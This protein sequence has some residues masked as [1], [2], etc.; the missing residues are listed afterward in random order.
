MPYWEEGDPGEGRVGGEHCLHVL[1]AILRRRRDGSSGIQ[2]GTRGGPSLERETFPERVSLV[3]S[4]SVRWV[5]SLLDHW[6][7]ELSVLTAHTVYPGAA[8]SAL[9]G[10]VR[11]ADAQAPPPPAGTCP[12]G[13]CQA[14]KRC[15]DGE[16]RGMLHRWW[17]GRCLST[18]V[19]QE[20]PRLSALLPTSG[21]TSTS[22]SKQQR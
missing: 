13:G 2:R 1:R 9:L 10:A 5:R 12:H 8:V 20:R 18:L 21:R 16:S 4:L 14:Q 11:N 6:S 19:C 17:R 22:A 15:L 7:A 3:P